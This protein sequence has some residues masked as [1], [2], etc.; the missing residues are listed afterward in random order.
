V[1][2]NGVQ[3][4]PI[5]GW[6]PS[7]TI[8]TVRLFLS[9]ADKVRAALVNRSRSR[10]GLQVVLGRNGGARYAG[11]DAQGRALMFAPNPF[12]GGSSVSHFDRTMFRNQL[13][14][15]SISNDLTSSLIPPEDL[16]FRL[17]Q[18]IGW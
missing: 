14:E 17:M 6:D 15:P 12:V 18:D 8:P 3:P 4:I 9:D 5:G 2:E 1:A 11:A 7:V 16:S 10:S 13:M